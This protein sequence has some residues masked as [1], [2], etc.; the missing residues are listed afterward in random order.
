M[1]QL[2]FQK[3]AHHFAARGL[4]VFDP[5]DS[6]VIGELGVLYGRAATRPWGHAAIAGGVA[7]TSIEPCPDAGTSGCTILGV[8]ILA[9]AALRLNSI[10]GLGAQIFV[11]LNSMT[12][13]RGALVFLQLGWMP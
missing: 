8:P 11:N 1:A 4:L 5:F 7:Y 12:V 10:V 9:E 13:Y 3:R 2:V 6:D